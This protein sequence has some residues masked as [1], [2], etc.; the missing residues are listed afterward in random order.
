MASSAQICTNEIYIVTKD[1][2]RELRVI[3]N[4]VDILSQ[5]A[6]LNFRFTAD[7]VTL[8]KPL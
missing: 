3:S 4:L 2:S 7:T 8:C 1:F 6:V 5:R